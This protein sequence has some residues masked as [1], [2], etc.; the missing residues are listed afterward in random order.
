[1]AN[2]PGLT[3]RIIAAVISRR[4]LGAALALALI[5]YGVHLGL[6][7]NRAPGPRVIA[8]DGGAITV[9]RQ[10]PPA[11]TPP[12][13][14][15][16]PGAG[17]AIAAIDAVTGLPWP[18][19]LTARADGGGAQPTIVLDEHGHGRVA[20]G[21]GTWTVDAGGT[22]LL[23]GHLWT[24]GTSIPPLITVRISDIPR[25]DAPPDPPPAG[26]AK[27]V[28]VA[29]LDG[30]RSADLVVEATWLGDL[31]PGRP[32]V[33]DRIPLPRPLPPRRFLGTA[34]A[35]QLD[36]L[37]PGTYAVRLVEPGRGA[38]VVRATTTEALPGDAS[39]ALD[40]AAGVSGT[41]VDQRGGLVEGATIR[42]LAGEL[43]VAR[44]TSTAGGTFILSDLPPGVLRIET[45]RAGCFGERTDLTLEPGKRPSRKAEIVCDVPEPDDGDSQ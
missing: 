5:G 42:A 12:D 1:M 27:L 45:R 40:A 10:R 39:A 20:L 29:T 24:I 17:V 33:R 34:G 26:K 9:V 11:A 13:P 3:S 16:Q 31:G 7:R 8:P 38:R 6:E 14:T 43:E 36:D 32:I 37:A 44:T 21:A 23:D 41:V 19:K 4:W 22:A 18:G 30:A 35:W 28:G 25:D 15:A 2:V